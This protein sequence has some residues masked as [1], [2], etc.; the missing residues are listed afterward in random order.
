MRIVKI[1]DKLFISNSIDNYDKLTEYHIDAVISLR[2]EYHDD[3]NEL[4]KRSISY[5]YIPIPDSLPPTKEQM[6]R[7]V[8]LV[9]KIEGKVLFHCEAGIGRS[10]CMAISYLIQNKIV[11]SL[12]DALIYMKSVAKPL[13]RMSE[14]QFKQIR[15][16]Y[17]RN[18]NK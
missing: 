11:D 15:K 17:G 4:T 7:F 10:G 14:Q 18:N 6:D 12:E 9:N 1:D 8:N 3:V 13:D 5:Y 2:G 16:Y